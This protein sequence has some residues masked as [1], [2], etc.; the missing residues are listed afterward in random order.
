MSRVRTV[1]LGL[2]LVY[3]LS[4]M[5]FLAHGLTAMTSLAIR[6]AC[7]HPGVRFVMVGGQLQTALVML[8]NRP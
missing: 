5:L 7:A 3:V 6:E 4:G 1:M 8:V 2:F